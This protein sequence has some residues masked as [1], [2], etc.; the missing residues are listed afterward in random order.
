MWHSHNMQQLPLPIRFISR[1][2]YWLQLVSAMACVVL[3]MMRIA[4]QDF[5]QTEEADKSNR[6]FA[7]NAFYA[8][9]LTDALVF[10]AEKVF[11]E[12]KVSYCGLLEKVNAECRLGPSGMVSIKRFFYDAY[13]KCVSG[14][15]FDGLKMNLVS[16]AEELLFSS[17]GSEQL[18]GARILLALL[19]HEHLSD[20][21]LRKIGASTVVIERL[22]EMLSWENNLSE[23]EIRYSA[24]MIVSKLVNKKQ[25]ALRIAGIPAAM[26]SISSLLYLSPTT[27]GDTYDFLAFN[28][29]GLFILKKLAKDHDNCVKM[30]NT[31]G[32]LGKI[33]DFTSICQGINLKAVKRSLKILKMLAGTRGNTGLVF[34]QEISEAGFTISNIRDILRHGGHLLG[35]QRLALEV[36]VCLHTYITR[37]ICFINV[38]KSA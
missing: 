19:T 21:A 28:L 15:I 29:L 27:H 5:G 12:W 23:V 16:F 4:S 2:F 3:S 26:E 1:L 7:L 34:R 17:F 31:C 6:D 8:L 35:L 9:A 38:N 10:L 18:M 25:Y 20:A 24:A 14:S 37:R 13:S 32:L 36:H 30:G 22:I 33:I 11:W